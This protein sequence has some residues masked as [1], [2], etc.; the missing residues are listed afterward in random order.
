MEKMSKEMYIDM[1]DK[2]ADEVIDTV[3]TEKTASEEDADVLAQH[4][5]D[6]FEQAQMMKEAAEND[7]VTASAYEDAA[8]RLMEDMGYEL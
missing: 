8:L 6:Y 2:L 3:G 1:L 5:L 4:A 7:Y